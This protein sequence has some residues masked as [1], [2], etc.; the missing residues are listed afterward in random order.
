MK[1]K[2][3]CP[4]CGTPLS[5]D[6]L[7]WKCQ[8]EQNRKIVLNWTSKQIKEKQENLIKNIKRL[9]D[10]EDP[11][12]TDFWQLLGFLDAITPDIQRAAL[13]SKIFDLCE[14]YYHAPEDVR[15]GLITAL[16]ETDNYL[17][18]ANLM[19]D[20]AMQGDDKALKT[21]FEMELK[22]RPWQNNLYV[23]PSVYAQC[24][25]W[26]FDK[27]GQRN[28]LNFNTCYPMIKGKPS[29]ISP[30]RIG[31]PRE[32]ICPHCGCHMLDILIIDG[33]DERL[34][35]LEL[36]G[37]LTATCCPN[38]VG[39]LK[40]PAFNYFT[41]DGGVDI[42]PSELFDGSE[43]MKCYVCI[44]DYKAIT[45]NSFIL[46]KTSVPLFY[47]AAC[48]DVNTIG[49]FANWVQDWEYVTCPQ[50]KKPMKYLAQLQ[51]NTIY[52]NTE[53]TLYIEFCPTCHIVSIQ[54]QQT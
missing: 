36:D 25:G 35:F 20:L 10:K 49:G 43:K 38:C 28:Q 26:T 5:Y 40:G 37:I 52:E 41:L 6:G 11:E 15:D 54:H 50:C 30:V 31:Q 32:D 23:A 14:L 21:L 46:G 33:R 19:S 2:Y 29:E 48:E 47:G 17:D 12:F 34:K 18:A 22:P 13:T 7:C 45:E 3:N 24:G 9:G 39:F 8:S 44:E 27:T 1:L 42:F 53:G 4:N 16:Q 51:W